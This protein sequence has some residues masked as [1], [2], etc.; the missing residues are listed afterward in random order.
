MGT[1]PI[2]PSPA[3]SPASGTASDGPAKLSEAIPSGE[4]FDAGV[5]S[6]LPDTG[7]DGDGRPVE[8]TASGLVKRDRSRSQAPAREGRHIPG[9]QSKPVAASARSPEEIRQMLS[10]YRGGKNRSGEEASDDT[11]SNDPDSRAGGPR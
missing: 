5:A 6:L 11:T 3:P 9:G 10:R 1:A 7:T 2:T 4:R 8:R